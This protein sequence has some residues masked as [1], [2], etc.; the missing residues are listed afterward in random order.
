MSTKSKSLAT[1]ANEIETPEGVSL[2]LPIADPVLRAYAYA[3]DL[4]IRFFGLYLLVMLLFSLFSGGGKSLQGFTLIVLFIL[5]WGYYVIFEVFYGG[6]SPG[7]RLMGLKV[8]NDDFT[9]ITFSASVTRNLLRVVDWLPAACGVGI[10]SILL[11]RENKRVGDYVA[12]TVVIYDEKRLQRKNK[13]APVNAR[14]LSPTLSLSLE[15]QRAVIE[16]ARY[17]DNKSEERAEEIATHL[18]A[19]FPDE[20]IKSL[21]AKLKSNAKWYLG[22]R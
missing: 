4:A 20:D 12:K 17:A 15:E 9:P 7:K 14:A 5:Q 8:V 1:A 16:F 6:A 11:S 2:S 13:A 19:L 10:A 21:V 18:Q 3:I 22:E